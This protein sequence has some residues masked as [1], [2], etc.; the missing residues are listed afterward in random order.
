MPQLYWFWRDR[1]GVVGNLLTPAANA[2][3]LYG[4]SSYMFCRATGRAWHL[5]SQIPLWLADSCGLT[6]AIAILQAAVRVRSA[7]LIYGWRFAAGVPLRMMWGNLVNFAATAMAL[8]EFGSARFRGRG[9]EWRKTEH[10]Y[11]VLATGGVRYQRT[12]T[13][14]MGDA[15]SGAATGES[16]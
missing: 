5:G 12:L 1:K 14:P 2:L 8:W 6:F 4:S 3:F 7:G 15:S 13:N 11:P 9:L 10:I 16:Y